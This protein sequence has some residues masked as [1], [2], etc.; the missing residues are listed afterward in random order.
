MHILDCHDVNSTMRTIA[1]ALGFPASLLA[2]VI[3]GYDESRLNV[4]FGDPWELMPHEVLEQFGTQ[5]SG[6]RFERACYFHGTRMLDPDALRR[7]GIL[8]LD[9]VVEE[10]WANL[11]K[12]ASNE[13]IDDEW[14]VFRHSVEVGGGGQAGWRYRSKTSDH[15]LT[16]PFATSV[17][18]VLLNP[19]AIGSHD[20]LACPEIV[21][22]IAECYRSTSSVDLDR[23]FCDVS[24]PCIVKFTSTQVH[25]DAIKAALW[26]CYSK[27]RGGG[28]T[29]DANWCF[30]AKGCSVRPE[31]VVE[32]AVIAR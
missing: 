5:P 15:L 28:L 6:V 32:V 17:R 13:N 12:L 9:E 20:Y 19:A 7:H 3:V 27:L 2:E 22:D 23:R 26:Y 4:Q 8:P 14:S 11:R 10:M 25:P 21:Q 24:V 18:E 30:D 31:D 16:G 29:R 1:G